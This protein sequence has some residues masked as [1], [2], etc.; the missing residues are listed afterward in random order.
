MKGRLEIK[1]VGP[2]DEAKVDVKNNGN[3]TWSVAYHPTEPGT[4][5]VHVTVDGEHIP[6]SIFTVQ[7]LKQE[8]LGGE[9]KIR[10]FFST[11]AAAHKSRSDRAALERLLE[12]KKIHLR[13][14]FEPWQPVDLMDREDREAVFRRAGTRNLPIVFVDDEYIGDYDK[15]MSLEEAGKL[16]ALLNMNKQ[17]LVSHEEHMARLAGHGIPDAKRPDAP[18]AAPAPAP[19]KLGA[20]AVPAAAGGAPAA[21]AAAAAVPKFCPECGGAT[22]GAKFCPQCGF[23][24]A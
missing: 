2:A 20:R 8:S 9:G 5:K 11:T 3:G 4:Y 18:A 24:L 7:V 16:D 14:D 21:G 13:P 1:V 23:K 15:L 19:G 12:G 22:G 10:V 6:G 17:K